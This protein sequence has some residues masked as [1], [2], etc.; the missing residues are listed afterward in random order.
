MFAQLLVCLDGETRLHLIL[1]REG[2]GEKLTGGQRLPSVVVQANTLVLWETTCF[3]HTTASRLLS[4][5][6]FPRAQSR[7][8]GPRLAGAGVRCL[9]RAASAGT[10]PPAAHSKAG[11]GD[12]FT[13]PHGFVPKRPDS[14]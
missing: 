11:G 7:L 8:P 10:K 6:A 13:K 2:G 4:S 12:G 14:L 3:A 5:K 9:G 1:R